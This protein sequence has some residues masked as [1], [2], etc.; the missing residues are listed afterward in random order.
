VFAP[1]I[2]YAHPSMP[3]KSVDELVALA[4]AKPG[5]LSYAS[6][7]TGTVHH[8]TAELFKSTAKIDMVHIP[9]KGGGPASVAMLAGEVPIGFAG[10]SALGIARS[11]KLRAL[12]TTGSKRTEAT[13]DLPTFVELGY[14]SVNLVGWHG[15]LVPART[16]KEVIAKLSAEVIAAI[17]SPDLKERLVK[18][19]FEIAGTSPEEFS[20]LIKAEIPVYAK[21]VR[22][23][24]AK[25]D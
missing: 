16:P 20:R 15:M 18:Q 12:A 5:Q 21:L 2:L 11:G 24:G 10:Y 22:D 4:K 9:Y 19:G 13:S 23:S 25:L 3:V 6:V 7:G 1:V 17:N 8:L 14:P